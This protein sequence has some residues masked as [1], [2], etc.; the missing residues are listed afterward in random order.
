[1]LV[2]LQS[3]SASL[4]DLDYANPLL[5]PPFVIG[6]SL[7]RKVWCRFYIN[8]L[9]SVQWQPNPMDNLILPSA[10][11]KVLRALVGSHHFPTEARD[12]MNLKGKG[13]VIL[14]HGTPGSGKTL[15]AGM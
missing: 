8:H 3:I 11:K 9:S 5:C 12:E 15:T 14:L 6:Y 1:M 7:D 10:Q 13:L 4:E 2:Y